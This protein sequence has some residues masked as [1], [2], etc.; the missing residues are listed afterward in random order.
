MRW[1]QTSFR[2][3]S[4]NRTSALA[5]TALLVAAFVIAVLASLPS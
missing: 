3:R 2:T 4:T 1:T 5:I